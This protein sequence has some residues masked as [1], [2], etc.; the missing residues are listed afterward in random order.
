MQNSTKDHK[1]DIQLS[2]QCTTR[3]ELEWVGL[4]ESIEYHKVVVQSYPNSFCLIDDLILLFDK[5][6][7]PSVLTYGKNKGARSVYSAQL[8]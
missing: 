3:C 4:K 2:R 5:H 8:L 1:T 6:S 7:D